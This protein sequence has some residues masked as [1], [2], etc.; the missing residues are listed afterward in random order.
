MG[1]VQLGAGA[2]HSWC[3][4]A[5]MRKFPLATVTLVCWSQRCFALLFFV[6]VD[7][8]P[9][10]TTVRPL[11][12]VG[13]RPNYNSKTGQPDTTGAGDLGNLGDSCCVVVVIMN[14]IKEH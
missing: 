8:L 6:V 14:N 9:R 2:R 1:A 7:V 11:L 4:V 5:R 3:I 12:P 10:K 13:L